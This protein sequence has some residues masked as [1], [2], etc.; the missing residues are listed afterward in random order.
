MLFKP[1]NAQGDYMDLLLMFVD[2]KYDMCFK[3]ALKYTIKEKTKKDP[4]PYLYVSKASYEMS[5]DHKYTNNYPKAYKTAISFAAKYRKKDKTYEFRNDAEDFIDQFKMVIIE[6]VENHLLEGT[7][8][9]YSKASSLIKKTCDMD[10]DDCGSKLLYALLCTL[11]KNKSTAKEYYKI[12]KPILENYGENK[13]SLKHMTESQQHY[14]RFALLE[15]AN[16][17]K[18]KDPHKAKHMLDY[19]KHLYYDENEFSKIG[20]DNEY[21]LVYDNL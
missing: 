18:K 8:A 4:I 9:T 19:G 1:F 14:L 12:C 15:Y 2:E 21:K 16:Y 6:E 13:F 5:R 20:F 10:P 3:K 17:Y 11:T 7:E